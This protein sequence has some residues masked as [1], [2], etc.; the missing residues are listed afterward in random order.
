[1]PESAPSASAVITPGADDLVRRVRRFIARTVIPLEQEAFIAGVD[2]QL[3]VRLQAAART[4]G[5]L[6]PQAPAEFGGGGVSFPVA[7]LLLEA[8][9]YSPLGPLAMNCAANNTH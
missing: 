2:D 8:A 6:S 7:A 3:R 9:G 5:V 1:M 4:A